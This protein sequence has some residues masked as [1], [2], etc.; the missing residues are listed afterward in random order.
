MLEVI[1][2]LH[3]ESWSLTPSETVVSETGPLSAMLLN[4]CPLEI[5]STGRH[6]TPFWKF[7]DKK[8]PLPNT[9]KLGFGGLS[10]LIIK[11]NSKDHQPYFKNR[12]TVLNYLLVFP[13]SSNVKG[14]GQF[15]AK[16][17]YFKSWNSHWLM[18]IACVSFRQFGGGAKQ[19]SPDRFQMQQKK[20]ARAG[21]PQLG[22]ESCI[23]I[24]TCW[25]GVWSCVRSG[26]LGIKL[27]LKVGM[28]GVLAVVDA[29]LW[30]HAIVP[31][32]IIT[33]HIVIISQA[34]VVVLIQIGSVT[35]A[36][37]HFRSQWSECFF[38]CNFSTWT[39]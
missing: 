19:L 14:W 25:G 33:K 1:L 31:S 20:N 27:C 39:R 17:C 29:V 9:V 5:F 2:E 6:G 37:D 3:W 24:Y 13:L 15:L 22:H 11:A 8:A 32:V 12:S 21:A 4:W 38:A 18:N 23:Q 10:S 36:E 30:R 35:L 28:F 7:L 26:H 16:F 34:L